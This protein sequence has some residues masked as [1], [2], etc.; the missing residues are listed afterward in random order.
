MELQSLS[1]WSGVVGNS[2]V[3][4]TNRRDDDVDVEETYEQRAGAG[5][6][7]RNLIRLGDFAWDLRQVRELPSE[8]IAISL[9]EVDERVFLFVGE[10]CPVTNV[11][12]C[13]GVV[14]WDLLCVFGGLESAGAA[15][16]SIQGTLGAA[17]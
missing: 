7:P 1:Q 13:V 3:G 14:N 9:E 17:F 10:P 16:G 2:K 6:L 4:E 5:T 15:F 11:V 12:G 8:D